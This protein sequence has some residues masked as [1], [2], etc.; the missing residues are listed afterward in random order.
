M[1]RIVAIHKQ[2]PDTTGPIDWTISHGD[3][4]DLARCHIVLDTPPSSVGSITV[5]LDSHFGSGYDFPIYVE[6]MLGVSY[7]NF[8]EIQCIKKDDTIRIQYSNPDGVT[9]RG[10][11]TLRL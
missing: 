4:F 7:I 8:D 1:R 9:I 6:S 3:E 5:T 2:L 11:A 10:A